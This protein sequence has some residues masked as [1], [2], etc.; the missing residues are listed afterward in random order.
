MRLWS[1]HPRYLDAKG[2]TACWRE[3]LLARSVLRGETSGYKQHPQLERF[4][5]A[6]DPL[7]AI[8]A[9][10]G[11]ILDAFAQETGRTGCPGDGTAQ[12]GGNTRSPSAVHR[13]TRRDR[14]LGTTRAWAG[15]EKIMPTVLNKQSKEQ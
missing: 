9:Y 4:R 6:P 13:G 11:G 7:A 10:L 1:L 8:E 5:R 15:Q 14:A 3:G 2:L 12:E